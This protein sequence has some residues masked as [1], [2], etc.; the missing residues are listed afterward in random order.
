MF[1]GSN[2]TKQALGLVMLAQTWRRAQQ[3]QL[4]I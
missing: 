4:G 2:V 3:L 1:L